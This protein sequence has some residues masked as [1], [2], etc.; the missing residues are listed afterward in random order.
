MT[1]M[2]NNLL[3]TLFGIK[4]KIVTN[5]SPKITTTHPT[6]R[7]CFNSWCRE[8]RVSSRWGR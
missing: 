8:L 4:P 3:Q 7:P 5:N 6:D 2:K 1:K